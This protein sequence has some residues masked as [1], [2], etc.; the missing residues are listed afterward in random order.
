MCWFVISGCYWLVL[1]CCC[2]YRCCFPVLSETPTEGPFPSM[3]LS[4][5][6]SLSVSLVCRFCCLL[7]LRLLSL[8]VLL[9]FMCWRLRDPSPFHPCCELLRCVFLLAGWCVGVSACFFA[10]CL[11]VCVC[12]RP[13]AGCLESM[14]RL[15]FVCRPCLVPLVAVMHACVPCG[16]CARA[17]VPCGCAT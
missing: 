10:F 2:V 3:F 7:V 6:L 17:R 8:V 12:G 13:R 16:V 9:C 4:L 5:L 11:N 15:V 1:L 14:R